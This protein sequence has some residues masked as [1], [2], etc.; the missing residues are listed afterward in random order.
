MVGCRLRALRAAKREFRS[1][2]WQSPF[3]SSV[4]LGFEIWSLGFQG[5]C[6]A[7]WMVQIL[8]LLPDF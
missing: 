5:V 6:N 4:G 1:R 3:Q 8:F 7:G 2:F